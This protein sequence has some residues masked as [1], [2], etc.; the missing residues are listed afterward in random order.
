MSGFI[1]KL[2]YSDNRQIRQDMRTST[3]LSGATVFGVTFSGLT[4]G[5]DPLNSGVTS[6][7]SA[8]YFSFSGNTGQTIYTFADPILDLGTSGLGVIT[9]VTSGN[10][11]NTLVFTATS[12]TTIDDNLVNLAYSGISYE[13]NIYSIYSG[14]GPVFTGSGYTYT[15]NLLSA[16][17]LD[18]TGRTIWNDV[19]GILRTERFILTDTPVVGYVLTCANSEGMVEWAPSS[20]GTSGTTH[21]S[22][23]TGTNAIVTNYSDSLAAGQY[24]IAVGSGSTAFGNYSF[25]EGKGTQ[26]IGSKSHAEGYNTLAFGSDSHTEGYATTASGL[27]SHAEGCTTLA[28]GISSHAEGQ[29]T[30]A[31][32]NVSHAEGS[33]TT[34]TG[35]YGHSEGVLTV[36]SGGASHAEGGYTTACTNGA[37][38]EGVSTIA[39]GASSHAEGSST[40]ALG[41]QAHA[42]GSS[43][44][45]LGSQAHAEGSLTVASG[46][47]SHAEGE[48][49][50][51]SGL[52][53]HAEGSGTTASGQYSH[54]EGFNTIASGYYSH[55]GNYQTTASG[56]YSVAEGVQTTA[57]GLQSH[58]EGSN[59]KASGQ[60]SHA[61][62][63]STTTIG[64]YSH[65]EGLSTVAIGA[66]S[67]SEGSS[68]TAY[69]QSSHAEGAYTVASGTSSHAEGAYT[70]TLANYSHAEGVSTTAVGQYSHAGGDGSTASGDTSFVHSRNSIAGGARSAVLGGQNITGTSADTVYVPD[71]VIDGLT[72][73]DPIAT[74]ADG[75]IVAG[76][77]D[78][79]LKQ[80]VIQL[81]DAL[82]KILNVRG[83][84][85]E[86]TPESNMGSGTRYGFIAQEVQNIIPD[87]VRIRA[88]SDEMLSL[89]YNEITPLLVEAIK[90]L[91]SGGTQVF[92]TERI[93]AE[94]NNIELNY[95]GTHETALGGGIIIIKGVDENTNSSISLNSAGGFV[96]SPSITPEKIILPENTPL[97]TN[98]STGLVG[99]LRWDDNYMYIKTNNGWK[100]ANLETF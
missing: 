40:Q 11:F 44:Q 18:F 90:E 56:N 85:F 25:A 75:R 17:T 84:S 86:Y 81:S 72:S 23:S 29:G 39:S 41:P 74:D 37:H 65:S 87:I 21:W 70:T 58:S 12:T 55:S 26:A 14:A 38:A 68:T 1:T 98:D 20:G 62:G 27:T 45:A 97:G 5:P 3:D 2:D 28:Y 59:T 60:S 30:I 47:H 83:V 8:T 64:N 91:V 52:I 73:T 99:E 66:A 15:V 71:L 48:R 51:A 50:T 54:A 53:S 9:D 31:N 78:A 94:D 13:L 92:D 42:E 7:L 63:Q 96:I 88:K 19:Q 6:T 79:R 80:N 10:T 93:L 69:T 49:S 67:H 36:A 82:N 34:A 100:R 22:A 76:V 95:N 35:L 4:S 46:D 16:S 33:A 57:S 77:S 24:S 61:E 43:T 89:N 32:G